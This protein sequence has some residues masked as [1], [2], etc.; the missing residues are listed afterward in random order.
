M[1]F[2]LK[3]KASSTRSGSREAIPLWTLYNSFKYYENQQRDILTFVLLNLCTRHCILIDSIAPLR[4]LI[5]PWKA[6]C[7]RRIWT[8]KKLKKYH[9]ISKNHWQA[10]GFKVQKEVSKQ[11]MILVVVSQ[12]PSLANTTKTHDFCML[13]W[14]FSH[15][16]QLRN[17]FKVFFFGNAP[18]I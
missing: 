4:F 1:H 2:F 18:T 16:F 7:L 10:R 9:R 5:T 11:R 6:M 15:I 3:M 14:V 8:L 17:N 12:S 13:C